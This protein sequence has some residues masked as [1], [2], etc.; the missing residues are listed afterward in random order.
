[1]NAKQGAPG[2]EPTTTVAS[3]STSKNSVMGDASKIG[4]G[5]TKRKMI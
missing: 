2:K 1:L 3:G 4:K 5:L